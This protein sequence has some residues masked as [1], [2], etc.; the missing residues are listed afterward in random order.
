MS[1]FGQ[2][3]YVFKL[4]GVVSN[5]GQFPMARGSQE[6]FMFTGPM[7]RYAEGYGMTWDQKVCLPLYSSLSCPDLHFSLCLSET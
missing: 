5:K 3:T 6:M 7:C 4:S 1:Y 2:L